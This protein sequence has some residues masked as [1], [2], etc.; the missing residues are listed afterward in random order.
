MTDFTYTLF[1]SPNTATA[2]VSI[3]SSTV[4]HIAIPDG[5]VS[6]LENIDTSCCPV[7]NTP[8][9]N[10]NHKFFQIE[11]F[12]LIAMSNSSHGPDGTGLEGVMSVLSLS[13]TELYS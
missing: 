1:F 11:P 3:P 6:G 9:K 4:S 2:P 8:S 5:F 12:I 7:R 13:S 10:P